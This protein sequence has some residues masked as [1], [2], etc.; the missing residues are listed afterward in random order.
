[1]HSLRGGRP[2]ATFI[3][4]AALVF[5]ALFASQAA[6]AATALNPSKE[7]IFIAGIIVLLLAGRLVGEV[8]QR[9]GQPQVMGQLLAGIVLG[10]T[11]FG[12]LAPHLRETLFQGGAE[13]KGMLEAVSQLGILMLLLLTG[14]ETDLALVR[15]VRVPAILIAAAGVSIPFACGFALGEFLPASLLPDAGKRFVTALFLGTALSI[16]SIKIVAMVVRDMHFMRRNLGQIIIASAIVE[17]TVGWVVI[18]LTLGIAAHGRV[19]ALSLA[20]TIV[21]IAVFLGAS[22]TIGRWL[23][24]RLIRWVNDRFQSE[25]AVVTAILVIMGIMALITDALGVQTVLGA[26]IAGVLV[27]ESP[28]LTRH[29]D[30]QL[31][32]L[33]MALFAPVFFTLA[34]MG[35]DLRVL[36][37]PQILYLTAGLILIASVGKFAGAWIGARLGGLSTREAIALGCGMNARG[38]TEVI[39]ASIGLS[40]GVF[41][42][43]LFTMIVTMAMLTTTMMPPMLRRALSGL[44]IDKEEKTRLKREETD[45]QG[46]IS[47]L[48]RLLL[49]VDK[50]ATGRLAAR[51]AGLIAGARGMPLTIIEFDTGRA[52]QV[53]QDPED[54]QTAKGTVVSAAAE[55]AAS[56]DPQGEGAATKDVDVT[57]EKVEDRRQV[58][59]IAEKGFDLLFVGV[60]GSTTPDGHFTRKITQIVEE[61]RATF[62]VLVSGKHAE[63][64]LSGWRVLVPVTGTAASRR[65]AEIAFLLARA[66]QA[67]VTVLYVSR[68]RTKGGQPAHLSVTRRNEESILKD[69]VS[70]GGRYGIEPR[71]ALEQHA[72]P[73]APILRHASRHELIVMGVNRR[74]GER[75]FLGNTAE[76][77]I[78]RYPGHMLF[79]AGTE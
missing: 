28:I 53:S 30:A 71:T 11:L 76:A 21:G 60:E 68:W 56:L 24:F 12:A 23:V 13:Q 32:G 26:F 20:K 39:V 22:L 9:L 74:P 6:T 78:A 59:E 7:P 15:R 10:P 73:D 47:S 27:G 52:N 17:D 36:L 72:S 41:S 14:M 33:I 54:V 35:A 75:L 2:P 55:S 40:T 77:I 51:L 65:G 16:S 42:Q 29:I 58:A 69:M 38:S 19:D 48:E 67:E 8:L 79:V 66:L 45:A 37:H 70:L 49:A 4:V 18:S 46:F 57:H 31:R 50:S 34:G 62:A 25:F 44:P 64:P 1:M 5:A 43:T 63:T 3:L 61:Y